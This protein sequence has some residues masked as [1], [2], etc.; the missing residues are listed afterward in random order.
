MLAAYVLGYRVD[1]CRFE[2]HDKPE[3]TVEENVMGNHC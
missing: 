3:L 2:S 1:Q